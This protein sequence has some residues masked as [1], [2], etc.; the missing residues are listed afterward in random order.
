MAALSVTINNE[1]Y[2]Y[3]NGYLIM[4]KWIKENR[5]VVFDIKTYDKNTLHTIKDEIQNKKE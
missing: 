1:V 5:S 2:I 4:K 3:M